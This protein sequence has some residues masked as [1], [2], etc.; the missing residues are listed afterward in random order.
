MSQDKAI[1]GLGD[2]IDSK[3]KIQLER[4]ETDESEEGKS[5]TIE[6]Y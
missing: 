3:V 5:I 2:Q 6:L 4:R 1:E